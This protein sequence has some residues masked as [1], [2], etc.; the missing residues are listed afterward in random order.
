MIDALITR[1]GIFQVATSLGRR[2]LRWWLAGLRQA[3]PR[4]WLD[5]AEGEHRPT[6]VIARSEDAIVCRLLSTG[7]PLEA[8]FPIQRFGISTLEPWLAERGLT[9]EQVVVQSLIPND[10]FFLR[11]M[12]VPRSALQ[13]L[14]KLLDQELLRR[15]PFQPADVWHAGT[16]AG[17][18]DVVRVS[19]WIVRKDR[20]AAA[21]AE[22]GLTAED[23]DCVAVDNASGQSVPQ[24][25]ISFTAHG[26]E[27]PTWS[28]RSIRLLA[29]AAVLVTVMSL[30]LFEWSQ[31]RVAASVEAA[32]AEARQ[33]A[34][35][36]RNAIDPSARLFALKADVGVLAALDELS[37][38]LPDHT[39]LTDARI[40]D[41]KATI[42]GFSADA[43]PLVR[44]IDQSP[45]FSG[46][47]LTAPITPDG[48]ER[49][50][51]F[52]IT[53]NI[54]GARLLKLPSSA[55]SPS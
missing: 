52:T 11:D 51:R 31:S 54:R 43:A 37:R 48:N 2:G 46:A 42:S 36:N 25:L 27:D 50:E 6:V 39:F 23:V 17:D 24:P 35:S 49:K 55:R 18:G 13:A 5:W 3:L 26:A 45:I 22:L 40:A 53:F 8:R 30:L 1:D 14:P 7:E 32:L 15:T 4:E 44:I 21:L 9:R 16:V 10:V 34:Q 33:A 12:N 29:L 20:A 47:A 41:G 19:H 38:V 28:L